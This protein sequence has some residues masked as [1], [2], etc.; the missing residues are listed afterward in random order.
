MDHPNPCLKNNNNK[1]KILRTEH[2]KL[3]EGR[4]REG[5]G[6]FYL[7][8][9]TTFIH[10]SCKGAFTR[11]ERMWGR[12]WDIDFYAQLRNSGVTEASW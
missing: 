8:I 6:R 1:K 3:G 10:K 4:G 7:L 2:A 11:A 9:S 5:R 12:K